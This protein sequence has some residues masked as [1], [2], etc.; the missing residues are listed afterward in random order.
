MIGVDKAWTSSTPADHC[1]PRTCVV[2]VLAA[3]TGGSGCGR[4]RA[5]KVQSHCFHSEGPQDPSLPGS[6]TT[7]LYGCRFRRARPRCG[8]V[9]QGVHQGRWTQSA[10]PQRRLLRCA[11]HVRLQKRDH[12]G[13]HPFRHTVCCAGGVAGVGFAHQGYR[14]LVHPKRFHESQLIRTVLY[15]TV[16]YS[17]QRAPLTNEL[18]QR[19]LPQVLKLKLFSDF[20]VMIRC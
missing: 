14:Q 8:G 20:E 3:Y 2:Y 18:S 13:G 6:L 1:N 16:W 10:L 17:F 7:A 15:S 4:G 19:L 11:R 5:S 9:L 12:S